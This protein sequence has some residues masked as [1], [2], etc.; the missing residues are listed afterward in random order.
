MTALLAISIIAF[1]AY[2][3]V[4]PQ[5]ASL[6]LNNVQKD[7]ARTMGIEA[8]PVADDSSGRLLAAV[9]SP[10]NPISSI[11]QVF[12]GIARSINTNANAFL[13]AVIPGMM[14][15]DSVSAGRGTIALTVTSYDP[16]TQHDTSSGTSLA[17]SNTQPIPQASTTLVTASIPIPTTSPV[18][19]NPSPA[20]VVTNTLPVV[21]RTIET[22]RIVNEGGV[23]E[24]ELTERLQELNNSLTAS[25]YRLSG[26]NTQVIGQN[27]NVTAQ[28]NAIDQLTGTAIS[29]PTI[30]GGSISNTSIAASDLS[31]SGNATFASIVAG[32]STFTGL[33]LT[34]T[35]CSG[36]GNGGKLTTDA[37]GNIICGADQGGAG[38]TVAGTNG[39]VQFNAFGGFGASSNFSYS[40]TTNT[41]TSVN[42]S[43]T[44]VSISGTA[45]LGTGTTTA[46][47][48][49]NINTGCFAVNGTCITGSGG[50]TWGSI[51]GTLSN[52]TDL[53]NA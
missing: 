7:I 33:S 1:G 37:S 30:T 16:V 14:P 11:E 21:V 18:H 26:A 52:Q 23:S 43:T 40:T 49:F 36:L 47:N 29:N 41:L 10:T 15:Q 24:N 20:T 34:S 27:Y 48:G 39:Q 12:E 3:M 25:I 22:E 4:N 53:Q 5:G 38:S 51:T 42:A 17:Q 50:G 28:T 2:A 45:Y 9:A 35:N 19:T 32:T 8:T 46:S 13:Y 31:V 44:N 6:V